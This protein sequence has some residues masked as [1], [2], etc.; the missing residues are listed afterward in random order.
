MTPLMGLLVL[1]VGW[2]TAAL[3]SGIGIIAII[4]PL[5]LLV[6]RTP[7]S[8]G[9]LPDGDPA[10]DSVVPGETESALLG[11][12]GRE[13]H[14]ASRAAAPLRQMARDPDFTAKEALSTV[15]FWLVVLAVGLRNTVHSGMSFLLAPVMVWFL[16][17]EIARGRLVSPALPSP[18][19][20]SGI[21]PGDHDIQPCGGVAG[22]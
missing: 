20:L 16:E 1:T 21:V 5:A 18:P 13:A 10:P 19:S 15:S 8:M 12:R 2:R 6:R 22:R 7:E 9:L 14:D 3:V 11:G 17:G 4:V